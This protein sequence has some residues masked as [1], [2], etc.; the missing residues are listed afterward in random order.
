MPQ[1]P[2]DPQR[3]R[4]VDEGPAGEGDLVGSGA[5]SGGVL[6]ENLFHGLHE[7]GERAAARLGERLRDG[8]QLGNLPAEHHPEEAGVLEGE[9]HVGAPDPLEPIERATRALAR[10]ARRRGVH[11]ETLACQLRDE[12]RTI[13]EVMGGCGMGYAEPPGQ[14]AK[15]ERARALSLDHPGGRVEKRAP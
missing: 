3:R 1:R 7:H 10:G 13:G 12:R 15:R 5:R 14:I 6:G 11:L 9:P 2:I 8:V 4:A